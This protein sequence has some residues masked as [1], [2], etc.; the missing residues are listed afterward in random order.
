MA[1][2]NDAEQALAAVRSPWNLLQFDLVPRHRGSL[3]AGKLWQRLMGPAWAPARWGLLALVLVQ[4]LGLNAR[5]WQQRSA[6]DQQRAAQDSL[7]RSTHP[8]VR[9]VLDAP[10]QMQRETAGLRSAAG[11]P[12]DD[13]LETLL[14]ATAAAW[15]DGQPPAAQLRFEPGRLS[16]PGAG[17]APPQ[18]DTL[19]QR[20]AALGWGL[21]QRDSQ[22]VISK[23]SP[24]QGSNALP[25]AM[26][27]DVPTNMPATK[28]ATA[29]ATAA[30]RT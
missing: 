25:T 23:L 21:D 13:D 26:P 8:Q 19:R 7:L 1:V 28:P 29:T 4:V 27:T 18:V 14:A 20:L 24:G 15:P 3:A 10:L 5:A 2:R 6:L 16:L 12:G 22:L 9:A 11:V 17:W 30:A